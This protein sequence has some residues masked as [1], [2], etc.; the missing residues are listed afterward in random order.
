[1]SV[2]NLTPHEVRL[3]SGQVFPPSGRVARVVS[4]FTPT[5]KGWGKA[6]REVVGLPPKDD[7]VRYI[8]SLAVALVA[9]RKDV[10]TTPV[11]HK[12]TLRKGGVEYFP[13]LVREGE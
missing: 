1:M 10:Y 4:C 9:R 12:D 7:G 2:V 3:K 8:T 11:G 6:K 13:Y 5:K